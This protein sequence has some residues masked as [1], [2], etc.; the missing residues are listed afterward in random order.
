MNAA[1]ELEDLARK[2]ASDAIQFDSQGSHG[3]AIQKY[4]KATSTLLRLVK[5]YPTYNLNKLWV[6]RASSYQDRI[7]MLRNSR[8][9]IADQEFDGESEGNGV[10]KP[11]I[12]EPV[13][14]TYNELIVKEKPNIKWD[15]VIGLDDAKR[16]LRE[17][18]VFP[19]QRPDLFPLGWPRGFL[20]Y[21]PPG[22]GK[23]MLAACVAHEIDGEF[24]TID[25]ASIMSRWLGEAEK[26]VAKLFNS[27]RRLLEKGRPV[28]IFIDELDS[29]L[30]SRDQE[31]GGEVRVRN[32]FLK[33]MDGV[34]DKGKRLH[35]YIIGATNK[36][37]ALD[38]P[39]LRRFE[40]RIHIPLPSLEARVQLLNSLAAPLNLELDV[41]LNEVGSVTEGYSGSDLKDIFQV[42]QIRVVSE[43][44]ESGQADDTSAQP[45]YIK[46]SDFTDVLTNRKPSVSAEMEKAY[47]T[48]GENFQA[49]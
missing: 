25:A 9:E 11:L 28:I 38:W 26:N 31:V 19:H 3:V 47:H 46:T 8:G 23:T 43:L 15:E 18:I 27:A 40:K 21:G 45:R 4:Q 12:V 41:E 37:W 29:L 1:R 30:G 24:M 34:S 13:K 39:F 33:E 44:F 7:H 17:S 36:P 35:L 5:L 6:E 10:N 22:C 2:D 16:S 42:V 32:Q 48:W 14:A 49:L 20:L